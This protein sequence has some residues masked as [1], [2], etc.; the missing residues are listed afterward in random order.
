L[1]NRIHSKE[2][3]M[4]TQEITEKIKEIL[5]TSSDIADDD[6][7]PTDNLID[8]LDFD[9]LDLMECAASLEVE[10]D[11]EISEEDELKLVTVQDVVNY[12]EQRVK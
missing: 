4:N 2:T 5:S 6:I 9:S 10:F 12:V 11:I 1:K 3:E 7:H 8:D